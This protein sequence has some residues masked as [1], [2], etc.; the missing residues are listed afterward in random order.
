VLAAEGLIKTYGHLRALDEFTLR[1]AAGEIA[2]LVGPNGAGKTTFVE[3]AT[4]LLR[5][6]AGRV[7]IAS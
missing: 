7:T 6:D 5:P 3:V 2:G 4:G 1:V